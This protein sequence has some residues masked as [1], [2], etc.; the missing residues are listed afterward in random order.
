[1][2]SL[3]INHS[4]LWSSFSKWSARTWGMDE[5]KLSL[6]SGPALILLSWSRRSWI[7]LVE[8]PVSGRAGSRNWSPAEHTTPVSKSQHFQERQHQFHANINYLQ[9][10]FTGINSLEGS[11]MLVNVKCCILQAAKYT[12]FQLFWLACRV[13][14]EQQHINWSLDNHIDIQQN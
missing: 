11:T 13:H 1:M 14:F 10:L 8:I 9:W 12:F 2:R 4:P 5:V 3:W 7:S 6:S